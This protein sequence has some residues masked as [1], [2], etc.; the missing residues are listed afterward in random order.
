[1]LP[2]PGS[3]IISGQ[4]S[5]VAVLSAA[6]VWAAG[7]T[8]VGNAVSMHWDG[9]TWTQVL[10]PYGDRPVSPA[11]AF[12]AVAA[13]SADDIW[14]VGGIGDSPIGHWDGRAWSPSPVP[15]PADHVYLEGVAAASA[16]DVWAVGGGGD[17]GRPVILHWDGTAWT[18]V[19][20]PVPAGTVSDLHGVSAASA[21]SA[22]AVGDTETRAGTQVPLIEHWNGDAWTLVPSPVIPG[23]GT[24]AGI[25]ASSPHNAWAVGASGR[26]GLIEHWDGR[27][28]TIVPSPDLGAGGGGG[29]LHGVA[30]ASDGSAWAVGEALCLR[31]GQLTVTEHWDGRTW[32]IV[33][34]PAYG[35]LT[36]VAAA[37]PSSAWAVGYWTGSST[38]I[39][40]HWNGTA[41]TWPAGFCAAPSGPGCYSPGTSSSSPLPA[42]TYVVPSASGT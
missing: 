15:Y 35:V 1:M 9:S 28:W 42:N 8:I 24:L 40:E 34:S 38:A 7:N 11:G 37:S 16:P 18:Q 25:T 26:R 32:T 36:G 19:P 17:V 4:L 14:A 41:W 27:T 6:S 22:W 33:P 10:T 29:G 39:I 5:G 13:V 21:S 3:L 31:E 12:R 20:G 2:Q 23:G 30:I